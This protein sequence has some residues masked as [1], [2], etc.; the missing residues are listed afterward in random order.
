MKFRLRLSF[1]LLA[2]AP[3]YAHDLQYAVES[4]PAVIVR[5]FYTDQ[6]RFSYEGYEVFRKGEKIPYQVGRTDALGRLAF[7]P[8]RAGE[9]RIKTTS[10]DGHGVDFSLGTDAAQAIAATERPLFDRYARPITGAAILF[11]LFGLLSL[12]VKRKKT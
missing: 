3:A 5:L 1:L 9:W 10:G 8:D 7:V 2:S 6:A 12:F 11:G 4:G